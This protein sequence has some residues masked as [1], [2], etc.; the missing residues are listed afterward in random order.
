MNTTTRSDIDTDKSTSLLAKD[1]L[2]ELYLGPRFQETWSAVIL[3]IIYGVIFI[4]GTAGNICT[5]IVIARNSYMQK[6]TNY[7]LFSL[8]IS[9]LFILLLAL[10]SEAYSIWESYP[11]R[12]GEIF[13]YIKALL[14]EMTSYASVLTITAFTVERYVAIC[15]PLEAHKFAN[16]SRSV[17]ILI[18]IWIISLLC[19]LP[20]PLHTELFYYIDAEHN[21]GTI[22][23]ES[24]ICNMPQKYH[25]TMV[26]IFQFSTFLFF[27]FPLTIIAVLYLLIAISLRHAAL[28]RVAS[29]ETKCQLGTPVTQS[30]KS[31]FRMLVA[32]V[33]AFF[34]CWA[35][36]HAQ[37]LLTIYNRV[38]TPLLLDIQS[39]L[40]YISG[41]LY[42]V[43][44]TVNP[45]LYNVMSKR[46]RE[47]FRETICN[48]RRKRTLNLRN[49]GLHQS[50]YS[51]KASRATPTRTILRQTDS[52]ERNHVMRSDTIQTQV[53]LSLNGN[54]DEICDPHREQL[55]PEGAETRCCD[56]S[57]TE[58]RNKP[59]CCKVCVSEQ[60]D[61]IPSPHYER[62]GLL[63][64]TSSADSAC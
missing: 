59:V 51:S 64:H 26:Y 49:S 24:L 5:C 2:L 31:V 23:A 36:F 30:G 47:A 62:Q 52:A 4:S 53:S 7:Y 38:W 39:A 11:W 34:T 60:R 1:E 3:L 56:K 58:N 57:W 25:S 14:Q 8:A 20:Y 46:Y 29:Q 40:F 35:P 18:A 55:L 37:R 19:A 15:H 10:P 12:F 9:D 22:I 43:G 50:Y 61:K 28:Q 17:K 6:A 54:S 45:I 48:C 32:V 13:C 41:V 21:N 63:Y 27:V 33:V 44:S 16:L 42:F